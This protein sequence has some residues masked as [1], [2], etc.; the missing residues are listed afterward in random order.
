MDLGSRVPDRCVGDLTK[1]ASRR[2]RSDESLDEGRK[3]RQQRRWGF[4]WPWLG[5][6]ERGGGANKQRPRGEERKAKN[7]G[8]RKEPPGGGAAGAEGKPPLAWGRD[9]NPKDAPQEF[10]REKEGVPKKVS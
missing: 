4:S 9:V 2:K 8:R 6:P 10:K 3:L 5:G 1:I 7:R